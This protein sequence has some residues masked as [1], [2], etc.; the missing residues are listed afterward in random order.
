M[1]VNTQELMKDYDRL[2]LEILSLQAKNEK[3]IDAYK[4]L[5]EYAF[6]H[7]HLS[8]RINFKLESVLKDL[9]RR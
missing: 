8:G 6:D 9:D 5:Y 3:I 1:P 2:R 7:N 4:R